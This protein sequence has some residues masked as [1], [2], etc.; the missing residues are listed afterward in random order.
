MFEYPTANKEY[1]ISTER[2]AFSFVPNAGLG[3]LYLPDGYTADTPVALTIHGGGW[4]GGD[5]Y[6]WS[7]V[8]GRPV[9]I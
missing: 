3:N 9:V 8:A 4:S 7:G 2:A 6:S 1:P 5:R